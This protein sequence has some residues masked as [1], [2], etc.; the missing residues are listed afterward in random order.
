MSS[1]SIITFVIAAVVGG[2]IGGAV[3]AVL[4]KHN[5]RFAAIPVGIVLGLL[6]GFLFAGSGPDTTTPAQRAETFEDVY[7]SEIKGELG[8]AAFF[9]RVFKDKPEIET[10]FKAEL[11]AAYTAGGKAKLEEAI[12][13]ASAKIGA[14]VAPAY[15]PRARDESLIGFASIMS[16]TLTK[17]NQSDPEA[18]I[19]YQHGANYGQVLAPKRLEKIVGA[20]LLSRQSEMIDRLIS[21]ASETPV[22]F[23]RRIGQE[24][25]VAIA[26]RQAEKLSSGAQ[27]VAT[28]QRPPANTEEARQACSFAIGMFSDLVALPPAEG[29]AAIRSIYIAAPPAEAVPPAQDAAP[30]TPPTASSP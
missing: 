18:C 15:F 9:E 3:A 13:T 21:T 20:S 8:K 2:L 12:S 16:E 1:V 7:A 26:T 23:D 19:L 24:K 22:P 17:M 25:F 14:E 6:V 11:K 5:L 10:R 30:A 29:A 28:G 27:V 4:P